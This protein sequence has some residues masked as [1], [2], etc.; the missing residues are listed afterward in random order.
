MLCFAEKSKANYDKVLK[1][2]CNLEL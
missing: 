2:K 1:S